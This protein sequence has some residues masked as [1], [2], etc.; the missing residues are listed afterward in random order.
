MNSYTDIVANGGSFRAYRSAP[1]GAKA[2]G[3]VLLQYICG[4][5][6]KM[7]ETADWFAAQGFVVLTPDLFWRQAPG[8]ELNNDP[9][10]P[11]PKETE[12]ALALNQAFDDEAAITDIRAC[13]AQLQA[14][15]A[16]NGQVGMLGYCLGGRLAYLSAARTGAVANVAYYGVNIRKYLGEAG[17]VSRPLLLH[18]AGSDA[19]CQEDERL[20]I[21]R[22]MSPRPNV[23]M[24]VYGGTGHQFALTGSLHYSSEAAPRADMTSLAFLRAYLGS[25]AS[26]QGR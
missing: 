6:K 19:F 18:F 23:T 1:A 26:G 24:A 14:D 20:E 2:P 25:G 8:V 9:A 3:L 4:V 11:D 17:V 15:P 5:N 21:M 7:R 16:C 12:R 10:K 13:I 22:A